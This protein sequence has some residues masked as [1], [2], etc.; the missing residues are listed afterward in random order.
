MLRV[1]G[2]LL[3][4]LLLLAIAAHL[5]YSRKAKEEATSHTRTFP[6]YYIAKN[7]MIP[8]CESTAYS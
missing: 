2:V 8:A 1:I 4:A 3:F 6:I 5:F 7:A